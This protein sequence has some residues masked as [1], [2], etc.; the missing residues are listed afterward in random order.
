M[1]RLSDNPLSDAARVDIEPLQLICA[2]F[3]QR[4]LFGFLAVSLSNLSQTSPQ[5]VRC[6]TI[7]ARKTLCTRF[8]RV[9]GEKAGGFVAQGVKSP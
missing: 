7:H 4:G 3:K 1:D 5:S 6:I 8:W 2:F 9:F